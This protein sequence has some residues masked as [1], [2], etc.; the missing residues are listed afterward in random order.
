MCRKIL[1]KNSYHKPE[2]KPEP[3]GS[4]SDS[5]LPLSNLGGPGKSQFSHRCRDSIPR[6]AQANSP[7]CKPSF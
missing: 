2:Q 3:Q 1:N 7:I 6:P 4:G 5:G